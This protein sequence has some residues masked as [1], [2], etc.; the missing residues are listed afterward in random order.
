MEI[1]RRLEPAEALRGLL[2]DPARPPI[3][4]EAAAEPGSE[5]SGAAAGAKGEKKKE[6]GASRAAAV[7]SSQQGET[8]PEASGVFA[9][10]CRTLVMLP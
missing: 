4:A 2:R 8:L 10:V 5:G 1:A 7:P 3:A 9:K 6:Q